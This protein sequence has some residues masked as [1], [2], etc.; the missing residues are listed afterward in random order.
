MGDESCGPFVT[1]NWNLPL[2]RAGVTGRPL[3]AAAVRAISL[4]NDSASYYEQT[5]NTA[6]QLA[7]AD[8]RA[9]RAIVGDAR[10]SAR[11]ALVRR[12]IADEPALVAS[13]TGMWS[14]LERAFPGR[15][16]GLRSIRAKL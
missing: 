5:L 7:G 4:A 14:A 12:A 3:S 8:D 1:E 13:W 16:A 11:L 9:M 15:V 2:M 6:L 10:G